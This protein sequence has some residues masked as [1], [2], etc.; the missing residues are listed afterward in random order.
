MNTGENNIITDKTKF[1]NEATQ[2][3]KH[4]ICQIACA[5]MIAF[6]LTEVNN[7]IVL[8]CLLVRW[9]VIQIKNMRVLE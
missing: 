5:I 8:V 3:T 7:Q 9:N 6:S 1:G 2:Q 4:V